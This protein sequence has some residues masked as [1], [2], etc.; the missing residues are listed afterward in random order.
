MPGAR[1]DDKKDGKAM[2][3]APVYFHGKIIAI[4]GAGSVN[5]A[6]PAAG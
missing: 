5:T 2:P 4:T 3:K 1:G 6:D